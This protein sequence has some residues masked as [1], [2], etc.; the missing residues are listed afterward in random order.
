MKKELKIAA[1]MRVGSYNQLHN[2]TEHI[3]DTNNTARKC[4]IYNR[5]SVDVPERLAEM[6]GKLIAYCQEN[7]GVSDYNLFEEIGSVLEKRDVF[8]D[9]LDRINQGE[10]TD[11]LVYQ[12]DRL[13][14]PAYNFDKFV[15]IIETLQE[16]VNVH[17][18]EDDKTIAKRQT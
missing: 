8:D 10:F 1:Y 15:E 18:S 16:K 13:Y 11:L 14:K 17:V 12:L 9:M 5:Y 2:T 3:P 4:A 6:R 7:L